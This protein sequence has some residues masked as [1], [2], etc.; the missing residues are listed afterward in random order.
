MFQRILKI[1]LLF[2]YW[3]QKAKDYSGSFQNLYGD[4]QRL[5]YFQRYQKT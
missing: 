3:K 1:I 2:I 4:L 5:Q